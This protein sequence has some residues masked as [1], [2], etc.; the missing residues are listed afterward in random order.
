MPPYLA[1]YRGSQDVTDVLRLLWL[2]L[3][4]PDP[5]SWPKVSAF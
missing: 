1:L 4:S 3:L 5:S 2:V